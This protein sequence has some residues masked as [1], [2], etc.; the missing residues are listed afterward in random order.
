MASLNRELR[1]LKTVGAG[2]EDYV[3]TGFS[4]A[5]NTAVTVLDATAFKGFVSTIVRSD[6]GVF[7]VTLPCG[8]PDIVCIDVNPQHA[9][10]GGTGTA[11]LTYELG[12]VSATAGT[13]TINVMTAGTTTLVDV[14]ANAATRVNVC[15]LVSRSVYTK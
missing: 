2:A 10:K 12:A 5:P 15:M 1:P 7:T 14:P 9:T 6:T 11:G 8:F 4:F 13:M 3:L